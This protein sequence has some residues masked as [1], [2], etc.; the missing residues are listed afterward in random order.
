MPEATEK[1][2]TAFDNTGH[3]PLR[4]P[5][6]AGIPI[7]YDLPSNVR[8]AD[9]VV[10]WRQAPAVTARELTMVT[11]M[12][13]LTDRPAWDVDVFDDEVVAKWKQE[14]FD[15]TPLMSEKAWGWCI[16]E[17]RDKAVDLRENH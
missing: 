15:I 1:A 6:F 13:H 7:Q 4:V 17:L 3:G 8:F 5:G 11:V 14:T 9:G 16:K 2:H 10:E 12:N